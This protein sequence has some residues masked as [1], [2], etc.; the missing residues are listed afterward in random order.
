MIKPIKELWKEKTSD[1]AILLGTGSSINE[2]EEWD[3]ILIHDTLAMNNW[4]Y[5]PTIIPKW[6]SLEL[7]KYD[8]EIQKKRLEEKWNLGWKNV[9]FLLS[10]DRV[11]YVSGAIGHPEEARI[12]VYNHVIR[13]KHPK[14]NKDIKINAD[15]NPND[16]NL[17]KSYDS[18]VTTMIHLLYLMGYKYIIL[19][20]LDMN[21]GLYFWSSGHPKYGLTHCRTNKDHK[22]RDPKSPHNV[23]HIKDYI[24]DFNNRHMIPYGREIFV[25]HKSTALYPHLSLWKW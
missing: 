20:G 23:A 18:S 16:G 3:K 9:C 5:H 4:V 11:F 21:N 7:K 25:G 15:F 10:S 22:G 8:Y 17:Y 2:I 19:Y 6:N 12:Y 13:G 24:I 1:I 14:V